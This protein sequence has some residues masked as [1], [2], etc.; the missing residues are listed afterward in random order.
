MSNVLGMPYAEGLTPTGYELPAEMTADAWLDVGR[1][2][3]RVRGSVTWWVG[4]WW[5]YGEHAYGE[6]KAMVEAEDWEGPRF[7]TCMDA[8]TVCLA[9]TTSRRREV[10]SYSAHREV[11]PLPSEYQNQVLTWAEEGQRSVREIRDEV[12]RIRAFLAQGWT[13][14]QLA[15]K[16]QAEAGQCVAAN[17]RQGRDGQRVD[18]AL[19][20]WAEW[21]DLFV[22]IDRKTEWGNPFEVPDDGDRDKVCDLFAK[23]CAQ[24]RSPALAG[25]ILGCWCHP[26]PCHGH[27]IAECVNRA[28]AEGKTV[29]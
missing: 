13:H 8:A 15:R 22:R 10:L 6:R 27:L 16:A 23:M 14:D 18:E 12:K 4:D 29:A 5:A 26:E 17:L 19:L 2:L 24:A 20:A 25:K 21:A 1:A 9:F 28:N 11:L 7:Q 3:G